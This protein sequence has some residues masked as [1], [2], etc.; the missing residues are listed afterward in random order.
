MISTEFQALIFAGTPESWASDFCMVEM[1]AAQARSAPIFV[2][3]VCGPIPA[4]Q[5]GRLWL[6]L[7]DLREPA[8][9]SL[10]E[11]LGSAIRDRVEF[12][13]RVRQMVR[14][15]DPLESAE[16]ARD[17]A[18]VTRPVILSENA[19]VL[20]RHFGAVQNAQLQYWL[21]RA[22]GRAATPQALGILQELKKSSPGRFALTG[23][24]EAIEAFE[25][26]VDLKEDFQ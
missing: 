19:D 24:E 16:A 4:H 1:E 15:A 10:M 11:R 3:R 2:L 14:T 12:V 8:F 22:I 13:A 18:V 7:E 21:A 17:L 20:A 6:E 5:A 26:R 9:S 25:T 23:V